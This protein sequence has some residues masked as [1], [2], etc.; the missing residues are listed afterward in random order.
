MKTSP[1]QTA[2]LNQNR[3]NCQ[4]TNTLLKGIF[5]L[6][7]GRRNHGAVHPVAL[8]CF[9]STWIKLLKLDGLRITNVYI[10]IYLSLLILLYGLI[11]I[12]NKNADILIISI[13]YFANHRPSEARNE[14]ISCSPVSKTKTDWTTKRGS[15]SL[16]T[17]EYMEEQYLQVRPMQEKEE[18]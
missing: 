12:F 3:R 17:C 15:C 4:T 11:N 6:T 7:A 13:S 2:G 16:W 18:I 9:Q 5:Y 1:Q 10:N 8:T 14:F